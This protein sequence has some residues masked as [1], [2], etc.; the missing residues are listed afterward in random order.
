VAAGLSGPW[1]TECAEDRDAIVRALGG[2]DT[3]DELA[4][5][6]LDDV[7]WAEAVITSRAF[8]LSTG[9]EAQVDEDGDGYE[10]DDGFEVGDDAK[11][12]SFIEDL[13]AEDGTDGVDDPDDGD[14]GGD[15]DTFAAFGGAARDTDDDDPWENQGTFLAL[16]PWADA[17]NHDVDAGPEAG[18]EGKLSTPLHAESAHLEPMIEPIRL[19]GHSRVGRHFQ[20]NESRCAQGCV[21]RRLALE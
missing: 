9:E 1:S 4:W 13:N 12:Y 14:N 7:L 6:C 5:P 3:D 21:A 15:D 17:L 16:V 8:Y 2:Q 19:S 10:G 11:Q 20:I 18:R